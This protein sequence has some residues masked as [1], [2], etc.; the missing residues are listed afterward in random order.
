MHLR[1][2]LLTRPTFF[3]LGPQS[4]SLHTALPHPEARP[5][6]HLFQPCWES[7]IP[8]TQGSQLQGGGQARAGPEGLDVLVGVA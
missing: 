1:G 2:H 4:P 5:I 6:L 3:T 7:Q 8:R